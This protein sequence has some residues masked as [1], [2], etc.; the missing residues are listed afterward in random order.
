MLLLAT[1]YELDYP[2]LDRDDLA[3]PAGVDAPQLYLNVFHP[4][5]DDLFVMG[6]VEATGLGWEGR[7]QQ[8]LLVARY[9]AHRRAGTGATG[10][11][12][13]A[14]RERSTQREDGGYDYLP[15]ARMAYYVDKQTYLDALSA[16]LAELPELPEPPAAPTRRAGERVHA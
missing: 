10:A 2:F 1:G 13:R 11:L 8:A 14:R 6:M 16:H 12:D 4:E 3:W 15:L 5:R 9:L 7:H